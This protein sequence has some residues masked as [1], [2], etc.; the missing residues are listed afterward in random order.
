MATVTTKKL[1]HIWDDFSGGLNF[2]DHRLELGV[3]QLSSDSYNVNILDAGRMIARRSV[4]QNGIG[5]IKTPLPQVRDN[6]A[7]IYYSSALDRWM[8]QIDTDIYK[9]DT[10][11]GAWS[12]SIQNSG[13]NTNGVQFIDFNG[14]VYWVNTNGVYS[15]DGTTVTQRSSVAKGRTIAVFQNKLWVG[16]NIDST[17]WWSNAGDGHTWTTG[18]DFN[19]IRE[20]NDKKINALLGGAALFIFK[21]DSIYRLNDSTSGSYTTIDWFV[22]AGNDGTGSSADIGCVCPLQNG[23]FLVLSINGLFRGDGINQMQ[24]INRLVPAVKAPTSPS[25]PQCFMVSA[26]EKT[27][28]Q[29]GTGQLYEYDSETGWLLRH[30]LSGVLGPSLGHVVIMAEYAR[31]ADGVSIMGVSDDGNALALEGMWDRRSTGATENGQTMNSAAYSGFHIP[32]GEYEARLILCRFFANYTGSASPQLGVTWL[33]KDDTFSSSTKILPETD[34]DA[35]LLD[36]RP[37]LRSRGFGYSVTEAGGTPPT[38]WYLARIRH[39]Y[40]SIEM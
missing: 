14:E 21:S 27:L 26:R 16:S 8:L 17:L 25:L 2:R 6:S 33:G 31:G 9:G 12:A 28:I 11:G 34:N 32:N 1:G 30:T 5:N 39:T 4:C 13:G 36:F 35:R 3:N 40:A 10:A 22:G 23:G 7:T 29:I 24:R 18:T 20:K 19:K 15:Y 37:Y 38:S